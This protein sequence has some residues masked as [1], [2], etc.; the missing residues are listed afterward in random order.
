[1]N[2][3]GAV[4][5]FVQAGRRMD[6]RAFTVESWPAEGIAVVSH[7]DGSIEAVSLAPRER[8]SIE[9]VPLDLPDPAPFP[10]ELLGA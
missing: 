9:L 6:G 8:E 4:S 10:R 2:E 5:V 3:E 1:M 7:P